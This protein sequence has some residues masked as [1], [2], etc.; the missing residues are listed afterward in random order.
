MVVGLNVSTVIFS[1]W[2]ITGADVSVPFF[3]R[4]LG[5]A[6]EAP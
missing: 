2:A 3:V 6:G 5:V 4:R 1:A